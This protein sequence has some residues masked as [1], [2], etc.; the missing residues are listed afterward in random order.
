M[1]KLDFIQDL[2]EIMDLEDDTELAKDT[3]LQNLEEFDSLTLLS[4]IAFVDEHFQMTLSQTQLVSITTV[5]S[6][7][8]M[9]GLQYF[10]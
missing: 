7:M 4:L 10:E 1:K 9:I 8:E 6:L 3:N 2:R 5:H